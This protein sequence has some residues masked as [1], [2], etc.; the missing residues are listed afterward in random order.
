MTPLQKHASS[1]VVVHAG[2]ENGMNMEECPQCRAL[3]WHL[4]SVAVDYLCATQQRGIDR[5]IVK[6][7]KKHL[8]EAEEQFNLHRATHQD[9]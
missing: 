9:A 5:D 2:C 8:D 7:M 6:T 1:S 4:R 3:D